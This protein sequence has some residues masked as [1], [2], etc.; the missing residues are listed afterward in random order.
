MQM[1]L[2]SL[3]LGCKGVTLP[4]PASF[5]A[6]KIIAA[7][8]AGDYK[9]ASRL[10]LQFALFPARWM[11]AGLATVMKAAMTCL[12]VPCGGPYPPYPPLNDERLVQVQA[13]LKTTDLK[14]AK[15]A[16]L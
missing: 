2:A 8:M 7:F 14:I 4:P 12:G 16:A 1:L 10:Q 13:F 9:E 5:I 11:D 6:N 3:M 15:S